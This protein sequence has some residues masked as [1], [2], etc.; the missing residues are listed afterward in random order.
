MSYA[1]WNFKDLQ[2]NFLRFEKRNALSR[3]GVPDIHE[4]DNITLAGFR[5]SMSTSRQH[6]AHALTTV[7]PYNYRD[8]AICVK[9]LLTSMRI[10]L[11][12]R[13]CQADSERSL[14]LS[15]APCSSN[16]NPKPPRPGYVEWFQMT[17]KLILE[18]LPAQSRAIFMQ[19]D[20]KACHSDCFAAKF[21]P[22]ALCF[23]LTRSKTLASGGIMRYLIQFP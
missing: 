12:W 22:A 7:F 3:G 13:T 17:V 9:F 2:N 18:K 20:V 14:K 10:S 23:Y 5:L 16:F 11:V 15:R 4:L 1:F 6:I 8:S 19:T 21:C